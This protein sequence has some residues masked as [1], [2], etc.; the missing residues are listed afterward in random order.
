MSNGENQKNNREETPE[1][2][3]PKPRLR[4]DVYIRFADGHYVANFNHGEPR[5][6]HDM[7]D[8]LAAIK[9][10]AAKLTVST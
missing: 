8:L 6:F 4:V 5:I 3:S 9:V 7:E 1:P 2:L 10:E